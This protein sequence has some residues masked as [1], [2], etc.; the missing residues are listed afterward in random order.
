MALLYGVAMQI[1]FN[2]AAWDWWAGGSFGGRRFDSCYVAF[3]FGLAAFVSWP[4]RLANWF[5]ERK[6][7]P[8]WARFLRP[9]GFVAATVTLAFFCIVALGNADLVS[10]TSAPTLMSSG[11]SAL[12]KEIFN[13]GSP[14]WNQTV[15]TLSKWTT[16]PA[17]HWFSFVHDAPPDAY[18]WCV[19]KHFMGETF[20]GLNAR[21]PAR[22]QE[23]RLHPSQPFLVGHVPGSV[24]IKPQANEL[25]ML[26]PINRKH[27][28]LVVRIDTD[29]PV[30]SGSLTAIWNGKTV[31]LALIGHSVQFVVPTFERG[32]ND[33]NL[34][35]DRELQFISFGLAVQNAGLP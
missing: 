20:P 18:D 16:A 8:V 15:A 4:L 32:V 31:S 23:V 6:S 3:S 7:G 5:V 33:L 13:R 34:I 22:S 17:R 10:K 35:T 30:K 28:S 1:L 19:G 14:P 2:G 21:P 27:G 26:L 29:R 25:K 12:Y 11:G 24:P 9:A